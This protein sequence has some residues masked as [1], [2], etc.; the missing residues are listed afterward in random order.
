MVK[1]SC[2]FDCQC[3]S[4]SVFGNRRTRLNVGLYSSRDDLAMCPSCQMIHVRS[5]SS[6]GHLPSLKC[7]NKWAVS[8]SF[9][10]PERR[11]Q[12]CLSLN[13][14]F[15]DLRAVC[16]VHRGHRG[17]GAPNLACPDNKS[18]ALYL[19]G[20]L[21]LLWCRQKVSGQLAG[22]SA[23]MPGTGMEEKHSDP[24]GIAGK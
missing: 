23:V 6:Q 14:F 21:P 20:G 18:S 4:F 12:L 9:A 22:F 3:F 10:F 19:L 2:L 17:V 11:L 13:P 7:P 5:L 15:A 1:V 16:T 8:E 24:A